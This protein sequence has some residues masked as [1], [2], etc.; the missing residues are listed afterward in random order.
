[1]VSTECARLNST[2]ATGL[3]TAQPSSRQPLESSRP[4]PETLAFSWGTLA[5][6]DVGLGRRGREDDKGGAP[7]LMA[8]LQQPPQAGFLHLFWQLG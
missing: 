6:M 2:S 1:M 5:D 4:A 3:V 8:Q 7:S